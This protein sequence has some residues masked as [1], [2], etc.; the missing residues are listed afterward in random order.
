MLLAFQARVCKLF[1]LNWTFFA[2]QHND[3]L[4]IFIIVGI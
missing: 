1:V 3:L 4:H 2:R